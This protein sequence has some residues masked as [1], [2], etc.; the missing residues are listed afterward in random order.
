MITLQQCRAT[1]Q[2][3]PAS[4]RL[5]GS[6]ARVPASL[7]APQVAPQQL[8]LQQQQQWRRRRRAC[9]VASAGGGVMGG[10]MEKM[11]A[12]NAEALARKEGKQLVGKRTGGVKPLS[13]FPPEIVNRKPEVSNQVLL[14]SGCMCVTGALSHATADKLL[15]YVNEESERAKAEVTSGKVPF[16]DRFGGVNCRG[17]NGMFGNRQDMFMPMSEPIVREGLEE[18][19]QRLGPLLQE[20]IGAD[21][22][23]HEISSLV[24]DPGSP[25][26]CIHADTIHMPCPQYPDVSVEPLYTFFVA[27]QDVEDNMGHTTFLPQTQTAD[28]HLMWNSSPKAKEKFIEANPAVI[29]SLKKGDVAIFDSR[30]LHCGCANTS[31]KRRVL[32]Y[33]TASSMQR[34]PLPGGLHGSNSRRPEDAWKWQLKDLGLV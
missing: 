29:S 26:Q 5:H 33:F 31:D 12:A 19:V 3:P 7:R 22:M 4:G 14:Q 18:I 20:A 32:F 13:S 2:L 27:L 8:Q 15:S 10:M 30:L 28:A 34:W 6:V 16:D 1:A 24:A 23:V 9:A 11:A 21:G 17:L 25:R